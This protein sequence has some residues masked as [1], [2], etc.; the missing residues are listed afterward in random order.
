M[1]NTKT[2]S[3]RLIVAAETEEEANDAI[4]KRLGP[5]LRETL[6]HNREMRFPS[7]SLIY[8]DIPSAAASIR[9]MEKTKA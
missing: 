1:P 7:G 9:S 2:I 5:W 6:S 3:V 4:D 8:W